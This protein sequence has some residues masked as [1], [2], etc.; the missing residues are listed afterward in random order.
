MFVRTKTPNEIHK[1]YHS[2]QILAEIFDELV[3][4][5]KAGVTTMSIEIKAR[6]LMSERSVEPAFLNYGSGRVKFPAVTCISINEILVHGIPGE[7]II[8]DGD[9]VKM[10]MGIKKNK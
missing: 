1:M 9:I 4:Y 6:E 2:G 5:V 10:E 8:Q 7:R 3:P